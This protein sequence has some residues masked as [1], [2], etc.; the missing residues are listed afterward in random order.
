M[1]EWFA[2]IAMIVTGICSVLAYISEKRFTAGDV[3]N[4]VHSFFVFSVTLFLFFFIDSVNELLKS[5]ITLYTHYLSYILLC[6]GHI[7][8]TLSVLMFSK[9]YGFGELAGIAK[10]IDEL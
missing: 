3:K 10:L 8:I 2:L 5:D 4:V 1:R 7:F 6:I 9:T